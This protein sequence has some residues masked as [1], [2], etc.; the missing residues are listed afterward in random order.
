MWLEYFSLYNYIDFLPQFIFLIFVWVIVSS[1]Y[2]YYLCKVQLQIVGHMCTK[3]LK[4]SWRGS[5]K[6]IY[7]YV[8]RTRFSHHI[9]VSWKKITFV[10]KNIWG[11]FLLCFFFVYCKHVLICI[12]SGAVWGS[13]VHC[14]H[15]RCRNKVQRFH[16]H[17]WQKWRKWSSPSAQKFQK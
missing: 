1:M 11:F 13:G 15:K 7:I 9:W 4:C 2:M 12:N 16:Q 17:L 10:V 5:W 6:F 8:M 14:K 3:E